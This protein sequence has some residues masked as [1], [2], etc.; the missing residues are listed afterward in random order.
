MKKKILYKQ[1]ILSVLLLFLI[2]TGLTAQIVIPAAGGDVKGTGSSGSMSFT[3]GQLIY[4]ASGGSLLHGVQYPLEVYIISN[5]KDNGVEVLFRVYPNPTTESLVLTA[6]YNAIA[7]S[8]YYQLYNLSGEVLLTGKIQGTHV[9]IPLQNYPPSTY[10]LK[11][12]VSKDGTSDDE[13][14]VFKIIK[15]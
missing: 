7:L 4:S 9:T 10:L 6:P 8:V 14:T 2:A 1:F 3:I 11:V 15:K 12:M 5:L 13:L